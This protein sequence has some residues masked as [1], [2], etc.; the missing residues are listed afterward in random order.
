M[1]KR[2]VL[3]LLLVLSCNAPSPTIAANPEAKFYTGGSCFKAF[4]N[5]DAWLDLM[6]ERNGWFKT[7]VISWRYD[8]ARFNDALASVDCTVGVYPSFDGTMVQAFIVKPKQATEP[9]P[10]VLYNRGG[11]QSFGSVTLAQLLDFIIPLSRHGYVVAATQYRGGSQRS[12]GQDEFGGRDVEDV[13]ALSELVAAMPVSDGSQRFMLGVS[14]GAM[15]TFMALRDAPAETTQSYRAVAV[16][17]G[18]VDLVEMKEFRPEMERVYRALIPNY[19]RQQAEQLY[20]RSVSLWPE[21]LPA[22]V[23]VLQLHG[24]DDERVSVKSARTFAERLAGYVGSHEL[25]VFSGEDHMIRGERETV[26]AEIDHWFK[27]HLK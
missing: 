26:V 20:T 18:L 24:E 14:R 2:A 15:N 19:A 21:K 4:P 16:I 3:T 8:E 13:L 23:G 5:Y 27:Q 9:L 17:G 10:M 12:E 1:F 7:W 6:R 22:H 25:K 11:N